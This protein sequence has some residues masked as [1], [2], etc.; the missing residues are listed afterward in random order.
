[1][2]IVGATNLLNNCRREWLDYR[3]L[4]A[5]FFEKPLPK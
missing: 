2:L 3:T 4:T 1:M 5:P